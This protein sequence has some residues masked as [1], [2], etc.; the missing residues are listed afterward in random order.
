M[1][2]FSVEF[3]ID[4]R[5]DSEYGRL[6]GTVQAE[7]TDL[8]ARE[9]GQGNVLDDLPLGRHSLA[10]A[11]HTHYILGHSSVWETLRD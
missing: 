5:H 9:K 2:H 3:S 11:Q 1:L 8:G 4:A 7:Q 10:D 6:A